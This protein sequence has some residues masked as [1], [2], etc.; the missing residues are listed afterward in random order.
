M[1]TQ[2]SQLLLTG[3]LMLSMSL[4]LVGQQTQ[5][6]KD[7]IPPLDELLGRQDTYRHFF[8]ATTPD[9]VPFNQGNIYD[10]F[11]LIQGRL[12]GV[13]ITRPG[14]DPNREFQMRIRGV[15]TLTSN[16][17]P[18][19][20]IDGVAGMS[21]DNL[22]PNDMVI[23]RYSRLQRLLPCTACVGPMAWY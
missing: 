23:F 2:V 7:G 16:W 6:E 1:K 9:S 12:A 21:L 17:R 22:D 11:Q 8:G 13:S 3:L 18:L 5:A 4:T 20:V 14:G 19:I 15:N 10:P